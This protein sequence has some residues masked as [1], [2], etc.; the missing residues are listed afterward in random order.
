MKAIVK[1]LIFMLISFQP[2]LAESGNIEKMLIIDSII[3]ESFSY[4]INMKLQEKEE[5]LFLDCQ[6]FIKQLV[7]YRPDYEF[8]AAPPAD[9]RIFELDLDQKLCDALGEYIIKEQSEGRPVCLEY[10]SEQVALRVN[11]DVENCF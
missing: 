7:L 10:D 1:I 2:I 8:E 5:R 6:S 9:L 4:S 3:P 11:P